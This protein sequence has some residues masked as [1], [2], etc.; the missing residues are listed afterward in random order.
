MSAESH[1][2][3]AVVNS[4]ERLLL[5]NLYPD[6]STEERIRDAWKTHSTKRGFK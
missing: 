5:E 2:I 1:L 6:S 3:K 4:D